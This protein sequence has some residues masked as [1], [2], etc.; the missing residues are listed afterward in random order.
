[1]NNTCMC[2]MHRQFNN[3][4]I[5]YIV[6]YITLQKRMYDYAHINPYYSVICMFAC[7]HP[8]IHLCM[9]ARTYLAI[10]YM[11]MHKHTCMQIIITCNYACFS[12]MH[13][14]IIHTCMYMCSSCMRVCINMSTT[15][16]ASALT[17]LHAY[18]QV[19]CQHTIYKFGSTRMQNSLNMLHAQY[20]KQ[21]KELKK[22]L[23]HDLYSQLFS[24]KSL[25]FAQ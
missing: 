23:L 5:T 22:A 15:C 21:K 1:M 14:A 7:Q 11:H 13:E 3:N 6:E 16:M 4:D 8:N 9:H 24:T 20:F 2:Y 25:L 10:I 18:K 12:C 19:L 17:L